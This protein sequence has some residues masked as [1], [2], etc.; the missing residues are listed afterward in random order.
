M[1]SLPVKSQAEMLQLINGLRPV[2]EF[3]VQIDVEEALGVKDELRR[4]GFAVVESEIRN[5][6]AHYFVSKDIQLAQETADKFNSPQLDHKRLGQLMGFPETAVDAYVDGDDAL[7]SSEEQKELLGFLNIFFPM[8]LSKA[9][10]KEEIEYLKKSYRLILEQ[11]PYLIGEIIH[12][13]DLPSFQK[14]VEDF[15]NS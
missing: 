6:L 13:S 15:V 14:A 9:H 1:K 4:M 3:T 2:A 12:K 8:R 11:A 10:Y 7:L 5:H